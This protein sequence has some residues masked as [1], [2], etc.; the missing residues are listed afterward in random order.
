MNMPLTPDVS[1][2]FA[3][4]NEEKHVESAV[5]S[6][7]GQQGLRTEI[8]VIDDGSTDATLQI[9]NR[10]AASHQNLRV[11]CNPKA[12]KCSAFN[13][14]VLQA[15]GRFVCIF[16]GDDIMPPGSLATRHAAVKD[17]PDTEPVIGLC[18]L[19]TMSETKRFD[20]HLVPRK[21]GRG[22]LSGVSP[23]M[24]QLVL[25]KIFPVPEVLPNE[26]TWMEIAVLHMPGWRIIHSDTIGCAWRVHEGNSINMLVPFAEYNRKITIRLRAYALF[27]E[28]HR[29]ELDAAGLRDLQARVECESHRAAGRVMGVLRSPVG[30][31]DRLRALSIANSMFYG[32][33]QR[34]YGLLS[35][36]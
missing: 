1:V 29:L 14:G 36:W 8:I 10:L 3:V 32:V 9:L 30:W 31:V 18:K 22:A 23:L 7:L 13:F 34:L 25:H 6:A 4:K 12:G 21:P 27:L 2:V 5:L 15:A 11:L 26:D 28:R 19:V 35:G 24:N 33:R 17:Y 16:A 20:G